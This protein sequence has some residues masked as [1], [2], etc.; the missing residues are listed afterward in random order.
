MAQD[1]YVFIRNEGDWKEELYQ[2]RDDPSELFNRA[3]DEALLPRLEQ[4][5]RTLEELTDRN[6]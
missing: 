5:R 1:D 4:L 3:R 2:E 6:R